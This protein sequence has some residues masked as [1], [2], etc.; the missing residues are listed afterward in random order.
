V[1]RDGLWG[2]G[3]VILGTGQLQKLARD[4]A[5]LRSAIEAIKDAV[6]ADCD[7]TPTKRLL[8]VLAE[9][10]LVQGDA[11]YTAGGDPVVICAS[12]ITII[13]TDKGQTPQP[14]DVAYQQVVD[15]KPVFGFTTD[16][17]RR[18]RRGSNEGFYGKGVVEEF[19]EPQKLPDIV[20]VAQE[21]RALTADLMQGRA[22]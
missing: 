17:L 6:V 8:R 22:S 18:I 13:V 19:A 1:P 21:I 2:R 16:E 5:S 9:D 3:S 14:P 15:G 7:H 10:L 20:S 4:D 12:T 11:F